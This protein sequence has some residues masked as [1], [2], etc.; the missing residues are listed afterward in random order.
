MISAA[1]ASL[2]WPAAAMLR[3]TWPAAGRWSRASWP[4]RGK[5]VTPACLLCWRLI[6]RPRETASSSGAGPVRWWSAPAGEVGWDHRPVLQLCQGRDNLPSDQLEDTLLMSV[7]D[8]AVDP[9]D[10]DCSERAK[11]GQCFSRRLS[12]A[13][14][15]AADNQAGVDR[16]LDRLVGPP[17]P[18]AM[19][20]QYL[21]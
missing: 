3:N 11:A 9:G 20:M 10:P 6:S 1:G 8:R 18:R 15:V 17:L 4:M 21:E 7:W 13:G 16:L 5:R 12:T 14:P 19:L 2:P